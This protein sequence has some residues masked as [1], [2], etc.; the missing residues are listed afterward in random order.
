MHK[1]LES[2]PEEKEA[3]PELRPTPPSQIYQQ[4]LALSPTV[5]EASLPPLTV[6]SKPT[7][8]AVL[9]KIKPEVSIQIFFWTF[10]VITY[11]SFF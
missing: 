8:E 11:E 9:K 6:H 10:L 4:D 2:V 1:T 5:E 3:V 7:V